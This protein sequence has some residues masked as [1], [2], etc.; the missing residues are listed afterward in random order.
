MVRYQQN[1]LKKNVFGLKL[2][3]TVSLEPFINSVTALYMNIVIMSMV[4]LTS[5]PPE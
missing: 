2:E 5:S 3:V 1:K 4:Q